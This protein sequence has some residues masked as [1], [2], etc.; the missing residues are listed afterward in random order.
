MVGTF[1]DGDIMK[2]EYVAY[3]NI[4]EIEVTD[5]TGDFIE[6]LGVEEK[7]LFEVWMSVHLDCFTFMVKEQE[8]RK[9]SRNGMERQDE[10]MGRG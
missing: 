4:L 7:D 10:G 6:S 3:G 1:C 5:K 9:E 2:F 8:S